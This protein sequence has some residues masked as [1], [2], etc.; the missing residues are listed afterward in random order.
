LVH[1]LLLI[2][3]LS[4]PL[5]KPSFQ[6]GSYGTYFVSI[7]SGTDIPAKKHFRNY[8]IKKSK[9]GFHK[10]SKD[11]KTSTE[12]KE[13]DLSKDNVSLQPKEEIPKNDTELEKEEVSEEKSVQTA[14]VK[15][16]PEL[17]KVND[18]PKEEAPAPEARL[19]KE[20]KIIIQET[21]EPDKKEATT[22][23]I[24]S[25]ISSD[26]KDG[27]TIVP[28][29]EKPHEKQIQVTK[30]TKEPEAYKKAETMKEEVVQE[31][32]APVPEVAETKEPPKFEEPLKTM[33]V[34]E[35]SETKEAQK[36]QTDK[37]PEAD[38][39]TAKDSSL[40]EK[41]LAQERVSSPEVNKPA[42]L[43][44]IDKGSSEKGKIEGEKET[45]LM[46]VTDKKPVSSTEGLKEE[47]V[48]GKVQRE[49]K[50]EGSPSQKG[51]APGQDEKKQQPI[52]QAKQ[53]AEEKTIVGWK[54]HGMSI[55]ISEVLVPV[56][57]KIEVFLRKP[58]SIH[59]EPQAQKVPVS[60][61]TSKQE[62]ISKATE[63][64]KISLEESVEGIKV[65]V[66][67][68]GSMAPKVFPLDKNRIVIDFPK[69][70]I[71]A[72]LPSKVILPLKEIRSGKH[73]DKS[74]LV[75]DLSEKM[76]FDVS[77]S[78]DTFVVTLLKSDKKFPP[79][80][81]EQK[82]PET[83]VVKE[84]QETDVSNISMRLFK[85]AHPMA[86]SKEKQTEVSLFEGKKEAHTG[87]TSAVKKTFSVLR[88]A[89][90]TYTFAVRNQENE[91]FAA[92]L[93]FNIFSG[94]KGERTKKFA[95]V[96][97]S[98]Q[99]TVRFKF[100]LPE[101][102]FWD[103]EDYFSGKIENSETI[104]KFNQKTGFSWKETKDE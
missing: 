58:S 50:V 16:T 5:H 17:E 71:N 54:S 31:T 100:I 61:I 39:F 8:N 29:Q 97:L 63:I 36:I 20:S 78:G 49:T 2:Y 85:N 34:G 64:T 69:T 74:R 104:T 79:P 43:Q 65:Q 25:P 68:N 67:G 52:I 93:M 44:E 15:E 3:L 46:T 75:L 9:P 94:K 26:E 89:E 51:Y 32:V 76:P 47:K 86:N 96:Q 53:E 33:P 42:G 35:R 37:K 83:I 87:N 4:L 60:P 6:F 70:V 99:T 28:P 27:V 24:P 40:T 13:A 41:T 66:K 12:I 95:A 90:G 45:A 21:K 57:L 62:N 92:D 84:L 82:T 7:E 55:P 77:S 22:K 103:D 72:Q 73:K 18:V 102:I 11:T 101:A 98:P 48:S 91:M 81:V 56:D 1:A 19:Q 10:I 59:S 23:E 30:L 80:Q 38:V 88:T 14:E